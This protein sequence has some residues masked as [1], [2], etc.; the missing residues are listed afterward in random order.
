MTDSRDD[1]SASP[2]LDVTT[3]HMM[4]KLSEARESIQDIHSKKSV[5][6]VAQGECKS[7]LPALLLSIKYNLS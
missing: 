6:E 7:D 1:V 3:T 2:P 5:K 4:D